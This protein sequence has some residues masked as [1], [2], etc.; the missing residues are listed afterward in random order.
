ML[1]LSFLLNLDRK[2]APRYRPLPSPPFAPTNHGEVLMGRDRQFVDLHWLFCRGHEAVVSSKIYEKLFSDEE[3][4]LALAGRFCSETWHGGTKINALNISDATQW[5]LACLQSEKIR[6][7]WRVIES[8]DVRGGHVKVIGARQ[9]RLNMEDSIISQPRFAT[10]IESWVTVWM[11]AK[12]ADETQTSLCK[13]Y[14]LMTGAL[15][16]RKGLNSKLKTALLRA[17]RR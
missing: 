7:R 9:A 6:N 3:I 10:C 11:A 8:G 14:E 17:A 5:Q 16:D 1:Q 4:F 12:V 13:V 15:M 2:I